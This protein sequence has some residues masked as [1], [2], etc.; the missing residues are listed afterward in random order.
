MEKEK[1]ITGTNEWSVATVNCTIGCRNNCSFCYSRRLSILS[2]RITKYSEWPDMSRTK[3]NIKKEKIKH[4][5]TV[6]FPSMHDIT[7]ENLEICED[8]IANLLEAGNRVLIVSKPR[9]ECI[10]A[11]CNDFENYKHKILFRFT[12]GCCSSTILKTW[13]PGAP[14]FQERFAALMLSHSKGFQTSVSMEPMLDSPNVVKDA[15]MFFPYV[16][17]G[18]WIGK[19]NKIEDRVRGVPRGAI[20]KIHEG[21]TD[22]RILQIYSELRDEDKIRWKESFKKVIGLKLPEKAG[23]DK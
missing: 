20:D 16:T 21:Q 18:V 14:D 13:E 5:G 4:N 2:R 8:V 12:I 1:E 11:I 15:R 17:D 10:R 3:R 19:M 7:P 22:E 6:M 23:E 9:V